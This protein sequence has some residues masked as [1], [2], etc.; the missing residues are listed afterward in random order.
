MCYTHKNRPINTADMSEILDVCIMNP[1]YLPTNLDDVSY[2]QFKLYI[3]EEVNP[4]H[5]SLENIVGLPEQ[6]FPTC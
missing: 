2:T 3:P 4:L 1:N 5:Y 6:D